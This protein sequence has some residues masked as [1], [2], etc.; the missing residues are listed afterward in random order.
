[1]SDCCYCSSEDKSPQCCRQ[2]P[3]SG[4]KGEIKLSAL[5]G[6][7]N[8]GS[9]VTLACSHL[10]CV[11]SRRFCL[12][13][14]DATVTKEACK[15]EKGGPGV[16]RVQKHSDEEEKKKRGDLLQVFYLTLTRFIFG[17]RELIGQ[18]IWWDHRRRL[19]SCFKAEVSVWPQ[20]A[21]ALRLR[22]S[23]TRSSC[24]LLT[25]T[26]PHSAGLYLCVCECVCGPSATWINSR[27]RNK[28]SM[29]VAGV[30]INII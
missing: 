4:L 8:G 25:V 20:A 29:A 18:N 21:S 9:E 11:Y 19:A 23:K 26:V 7:A 12:Y 13:R 10:C 14:V 3:S 2:S 28:L 6:A 17:G 30:K 16:G 22:P 27:K 15:K 5:K 24:L 1:M